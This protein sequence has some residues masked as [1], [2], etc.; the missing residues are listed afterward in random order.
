MAALSLPLALLLGAANAGEAVPDPEVTVV[1]V[2][3]IRLD[4]PVAR[5]VAED[6]P[7]APVAAVREALRGDILLGNLEEP[8]TTR[9]EPAKKKFIF[10]GRPAAAKVLKACGFDVLGLANNHVMDYGPDGLTDT[11]AALDKAGLGRLGAGKDAAEARKPLILERN[12]LKVGL[13]ALTSTFPEE[14]WARKDRPGVAFSALERVSGWVRDAKALCDVL[15]VSFHG[16]TELAAEPNE[17]QRAFARA[18]AAGGAD[19]VIGH[20]PHVVQAA[21]LIGRTLVIHSVGNFMFESP[22]AGTEKSLIARLT[23]S[24]SGVRAELVPI[25]TEGGR[26]KPVTPSQRSEIRALLDALGALSADPERIR[27]QEA[28]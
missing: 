20:H 8:L 19:A 17:V 27:L 22:T 9:G 12:G 24:R 7:A 3:D 15:V 1:V 6:G 26:P 13:L 16:G 18:A 10:R 5:L 4:G 2:G 28:P 23:L 25:D 21:E 14:N 11:L